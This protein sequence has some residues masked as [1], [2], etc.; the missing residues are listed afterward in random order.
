MLNATSLAKNNAKEHLLV[1]VQ[2]VQAD[3][4]LITETWFNSK[5]SD[6][7]LNLE[8]FTLL[9]RDRIGRKEGGVCVY[10][11]SSVSC[12]IYQPEGGAA[13]RDIEIMWVK[14]R[15]REWIIFIA[16]CYH[17]PNPIYPVN[18]FTSQLSDDIDSIVAN[19]PDCLIIVAGDFNTLC[20]D[21]IENDYGLC[22]L[23]ETPTHGD[24]LLDKFFISRPDI[25][26]TAPPFKS[27]VKTKHM[28][29]LAV[30]VTGSSAGNLAK[31]ERQKIRLYDKRAHNIDRLRHALG[32]YNWFSVTDRQCI[33]DIYSEFLEVVKTQVANC[34]PSKMVTIGPKDPSYITP[35][36]KSLLVKRN[37]LRRRG[38][39]DEAN[40]LAE[41]INE[42]IVNNRSKTFEKLAKANSKELWEAVK[43][44]RNNCAARNR[45]SHIFSSPDVVNNFFATIA[46][47]EDY[48]LD[49]IIELRNVITPSDLLEVENL[50]LTEI[51]IE[52]ILRRL[53]DTAPG[54]D[55]IPAWVFRMCSYELAGIIAFIINYTF[56]SGT[57]PS[58]WLTAIV[59]PV[60]KISIPQHI[61]DFRPISVTPILSRITEK[62]L[63][64]HWIRPAFAD[65]DLLDQFAF[66][67]TGSTNCALIYCIDNIARMLETNNYVRCMM[68]DFAKAFDTV[69]H[70]IVLRKMNALN[71]P[72]SNKN[73]I[74]NFLTGRSQITKIYEKYS[75][76]LNINRSIVQGS[77]IG[78]SMYVLMESDLRTLCVNNV[79]FKFADDTNLLVPENSEV[80]MQDEFAHVQE[81]ARSNKMIIN[82]AKTKEIVFHRPHPNRFTLH[83]SFSEIEIVREAKLLGI[84]LSCN[85]SFEKHLQDILSCC[86]KRFYLLKSLR[87][88]GMPISKMNLI[89]CTLIVNRI[90]YCVS[91]WGSYLTAE[92]VG[93][94]DALLKRAKRYGFT[95][96]YYDFNGLLE[97]ADYKMFNSIQCENNC[98]HYILPPVKTGDCNLRMRG[99]N[100]VLPRCQHDMYKKSFVPRCLYKFL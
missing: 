10:V 14:L 36:V 67:P 42:I 96:F 39:I 38:K 21:F 18:I 92:Q 99:H 23:V 71:M 43:G 7:D 72:A 75:S 13:S 9:R 1:D 46:R 40:I 78:P 85:L 33:Q 56:R 16:V 11:R 25:Y 32:V 49:D 51:D 24:N 88:G 6:S 28:A 81:W 17:P 27:L 35:M 58:N 12:C 66:K 90:T 62:L 50:S 76:R 5:H 22:Q 34:I 95:S 8:G 68:I 89:F 15:C 74:I 57:V 80:P 86:S 63:V 54:Y 3:V 4:V 83:P 2:T 20:T 60:P 69:D 87:E 70:A 79:I 26:S 65:V 97:H 29:V 77:G 45:Y 55:G 59:T 41:R 84:T 30:P 64:R 73:W 93:R 100:F 47:T 37:R 48:K 31:T 82:L 53:K 44:R 19:Q 91:A 94:V 61:S 52:P 98:L